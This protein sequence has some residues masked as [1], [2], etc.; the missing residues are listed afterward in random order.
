DI[1]MNL[2]SSL[3]TVDVE[4]APQNGKLPPLPRASENNGAMEILVSERE[5]MLLLK[6][7]ELQARMNSLTDELT[8]E[9]LKHMQ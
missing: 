1:I 4:N 2:L 6:I 5:R 8:A 9:K 3:H 7:S